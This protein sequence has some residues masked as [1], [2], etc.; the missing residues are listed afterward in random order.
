MWLGI[1]LG[2]S[3]LPT[4]STISIAFSAICDMRP[5]QITPIR[6]RLTDP[7]GERPLAPQRASGG[8]NYA[9]H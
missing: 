3:E 9:E 2:L 5:T 8:G 7:H 4:T 1:G 6:T